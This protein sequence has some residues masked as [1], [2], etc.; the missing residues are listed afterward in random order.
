MQQQKFSF[1]ISILSVV[2]FFS[3]PVFAEKINIVTEHLAP[4][5][6]VH[7]NGISG[8]S[9]EIIK[10]TFDAAQYDYT[11]DAYPWSSSYNRA[12]HEKETCIY[13]IA[14][15]PA[16]EALFQWVGRIAKSTT[17]LYTLQGRNISISNIEEAKQ[18]RIAV[19]KDDVAHHFLLSK[20][21]EENKQLYVLNHYDTLLK[22]LEVSSRKIDFI[23]I[24]DDLI[25]NRLSRSQDAKKYKNVY[26]LKELTLDFHLACNLN[27]QQSTVDNLAKAM[28]SL[29]QQGV[30]AK[31]KDKWQKDM[32]NIIR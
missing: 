24:N 25:R 9:T 6:I 15:I 30:F 3:K 1:L 12:L 22:L 5:Q 21:F 4:F 10:A 8:L 7:K 27:T 28:K 14:R 23:V 13:S 29:E 18:Y 32:N 26:E 31:I 2:I 11:I 17:S 19:I 16:R 20:G